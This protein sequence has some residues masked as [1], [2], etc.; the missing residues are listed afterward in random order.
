MDVYF[1]VDT[2]KSIQA[3]QFAMEE[4]SIRYILG[5]F[6][7]GYNKTRVGLVT[8]NREVGTHFNLTKYQSRGELTSLDHLLT[9]P[10]NLKGGTRTDLALKEMMNN[11]EVESKNKHK[12]AIIITD[13]K[14]T[15]PLKDS[16]AELDQTDIL[17]LIFLDSCMNV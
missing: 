3:K 12:V 15:A 5:N 1:V 6:D 13:G 10:T 14:A 4:E 2:S 7:I 17:V 11:F 8:F 16:L 9:R